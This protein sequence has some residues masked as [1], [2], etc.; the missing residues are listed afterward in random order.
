MEAQRPS[1]VSGW[2][3]HTA[4]SKINRK[5]LLLKHGSAHS[6]IF[7]HSTWARRGNYSLIPEACFL[8]SKNIVTKL[9]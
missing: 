1:L 5:Y 7:F 3:H 6:P 8:Q 4:I 9:N 2:I